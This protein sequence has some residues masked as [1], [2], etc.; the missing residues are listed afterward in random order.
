MVG[1]RNSMVR[2]AAAPC[3]TKTVI[4]SQRLRSSGCSRE[5]RGGRDSRVSPSGDWWNIGLTSANQQAEA[6]RALAS[7]ARANRHPVRVQLTPAPR[8]RWRRELV[9]KQ[10]GFVRGL[11]PCTP[12]LIT[13]LVTQQNSLHALQEWPH[14]ERRNRVRI[15]I[16]MEGWT[17]WPRSGEIGV[18][19]SLNN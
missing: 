16:G 17:N 9:P 5:G 6:S 1:S 19:A 15:K 8:A 10:P 3:T 11:S 7:V 14:H 18:A 4:I 13:L 12:Q 2:N